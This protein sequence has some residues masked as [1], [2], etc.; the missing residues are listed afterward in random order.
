MKGV[1][2][3]Q[4]HGAPLEPRQ[5]R[6]DRAAEIRA[7]LEERA[8]VDDGV[9]DGTHLVDLTAVARHRLHQG[10][11]RALRIIVAGKRRRQFIDR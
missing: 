8:L 4:Q 10:F 5:T 11:L 7:H 1:A 6:D 3:E 2:G 9:D